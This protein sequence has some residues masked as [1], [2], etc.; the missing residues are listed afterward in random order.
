MNGAL[1]KR[2]KLT[3]GIKKRITYVSLSASPWIIRR[4]KERKGET[5]ID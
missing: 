4:R 1:D 5:I 3:I 2:N